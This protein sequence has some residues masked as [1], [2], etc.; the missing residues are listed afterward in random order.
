MG[1]GCS[2]GSYQQHQIG[3]NYPGLLDGIL[4]GCSFPDVAHATVYVHHRAR[5]LYHYFHAGAGLDR[6]RRSARSPARRTTTI[7][8]DTSYDGARRIDAARVCTR[9]CRRRA[10]RPGD[11]P[12]RRALRRLRP[13]DQHLRAAIPATGFARRP[14]DNVG[15]QYG[16]KALNAGAITVDQF[17]DLNE[18]SAA[19]TSTRNSSP[20]RTVADPAAMRARLPDRPRHQRRRRA[21]RTSRSS[22]TA[23]TTTTRQRRHPRALP[24]V[25]DPRA[26]AA[27]PTATPTTR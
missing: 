24:L 20:Q 16:L 25:L 27:R 18:T 17:L 15:V 7:D 11:Q 23:P 9:C 12:D 2:G 3:D 4:P 14:L 8:A 22:T 1:C 21:R 6:R 13:R 10:L 19:S 26:A 5:L